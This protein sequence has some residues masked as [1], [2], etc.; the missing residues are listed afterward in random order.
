MGKSIFEFED[1]FVVGGPFSDWLNENKAFR[2]ERDRLNNDKNDSYI[3]ER[4]SEN[5]V[6]IGTNIKYKVSGTRNGNILNKYNYTW[7]VIDSVGRTIKQYTTNNPSLTL[8]AKY[9][10]NYLVQAIILNNG[11]FVDQAFVHQ[12]IYYEENNTE[13]GGLSVGNFDFYIDGNKT[14]IEVRVKFAFESNINTEDQDD[15]KLKFFK[16]INEKWSNSGVSFVS[17]G[18]CSRTKIPLEINLIEDESDY[19]KLVDVDK[20]YRRASVISDMNLHLNISSKTIAHEFGHVLGLYDEYDG[21]FPEN[22]MFWHDDGSNKS[23][24]A[25]LMNSGTE[26]RKR[27]FQHILEKINELSPKDCKYIL[28]TPFTK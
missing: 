13:L 2:E 11:E 17:F 9:P 10:G 16:A 15:F 27:Y 1:T 28:N 21:D 18:I 24:T 23:D 12:N 25:A 14:L 3:L 6:E 19:H 22:Y 5:S 20:E 26:L 4:D 7:K 8:V